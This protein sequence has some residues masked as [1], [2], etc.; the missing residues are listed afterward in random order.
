MLWRRFYLRVGILSIKSAACCRPPRRRCSSASSTRGISTPSVIT[1]TANPM[2]RPIAPGAARVL[3]SRCRPNTGPLIVITP[4][5]PAVYLRGEP[6]GG[7]TR[8]FVHKTAGLKSSPLIY[9]TRIEDIT[10]TRDTASM[11]QGRFH[12]L[13]KINEGL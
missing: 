6:A 10:E 4:R 8:N 13:L 9:R 3:L 1:T 2:A 7:Q 12:S 5:L 11:L